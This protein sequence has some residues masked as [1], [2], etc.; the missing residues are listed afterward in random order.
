MNMLHGHACRKIIHAHKAKVKSLKKKKDTH[1]P[2]S[3]PN[4]THW[5]TEEKDTKSEGRLVS[6]KE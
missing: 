6:W 1:P 4:N 2:V 3:N 5:A